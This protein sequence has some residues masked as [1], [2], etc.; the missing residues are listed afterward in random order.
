[1]LVAA[2]RVDLRVAAA[3]PVLLVLDRFAFPRLVV[4]LP[5]LAAAFFVVE[6]FL[7][8]R[9]G[10]VLPVTASTMLVAALDYSFYGSSHARLGGLCY[11]AQNGRAFSFFLLVHAVYLPLCVHVSVTLSLGSGQLHTL[12][13]VCRSSSDVEF[14]D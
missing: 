13:K 14:C 9:G 11:G 10:L 5:R 8:L 2:F 4:V 7:G 12:T 1:L 3:E 6:R